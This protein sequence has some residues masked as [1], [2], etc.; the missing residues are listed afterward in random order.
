MRTIAAFAALCLLAACTEVGPNY[1]APDLTAAAPGN[2]LSADPKIAA[3]APV[4]DGWWRLYDDP[5][6]NQLELDALKANLDLRVAAANLARARAMQKEVVGAQEIKA[7]ADFGAERAQLS[8]Q[9]Y[10]LP[11]QLP[12]QYLGDGG[13]KVGYELDLFGRLKRAAEAASADREAAAA[14]VE[15]AQIAVAA[16]VARAYGEACAASHELETAERVRALQ[17]RAHEVTQQLA[18][19]GRDTAIEVTRAKAQLDQAEAALPQFRSR[20]RLALFRLAILIGKP[21]ADYPKEAEACKLP[22]RLHRAIPVGDGAALLRRR[23]DVRQAERAIASATARIGV[24]TAAL[25]PDVQ[26]G[27]TAGSTGLLTQLGEPS[28][29]YWSLGT[30]ISWRMPDSSAYARIEGADANAQAALARF[31][32]VVLGALRE[33][34]SSL[35]VYAHDLERNQALRAARDHAA[36]IA[37]QTDRLYKAGRSPYL[38]GLNAQQGLAQAEQVLALSDDQISA[39][40]V[41]LFLALGGGWPQTSP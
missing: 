38:S 31:Q 35:T 14:G 12:S 28:A 7:G 19:Q 4:P 2:F 8:G 33:T 17:Q 39:D 18:S 41:S 6:L 9:S 21:P 29:E 11:V 10:L 23:P 15:L 24:A 20:Q 1:Q 37:D 36:E 16:E 30:L 40:Q 34:E 32:G 5:L 27:F 26:L 3:N 13:I 25:Y 22:P